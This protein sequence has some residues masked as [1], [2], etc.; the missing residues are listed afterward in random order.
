MIKLLKK[1]AAALT[2][3]TI[4]SASSAFAMPYRSS[5]IINTNKLSREQ[6]ALQPINKR[7]ISHIYG[8][9]QMR[10]SVKTPQRQSGQFRN[11]IYVKQL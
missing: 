6:R 9:Q 11:N 3:I 1:T 2:V 7:I 5:R 4:V 10:N 8:E